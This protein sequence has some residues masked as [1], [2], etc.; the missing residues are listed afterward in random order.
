[1]DD[2]DNNQVEEEFDDDASVDLEGDDDTDGDEEAIENI[3]IHTEIESHVES[4]KN[5]YVQKKI[6]RPVLT[7]FEHTRLIGERT[8]QLQQGAEPMIDTSNRD[9][10]SNR[11][12]A[13][14]EL[15]EKCM[16]LI[17]RRYLSDNTH[18]DWRLSELIIPPR[19]N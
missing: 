5:M 14:L 10:K 18:E 16:P 9:I 7:K 4:K 6:T 19:F 11:E 12:I 3:G 15:S 8:A 2:I 1:M 13:E 17:I